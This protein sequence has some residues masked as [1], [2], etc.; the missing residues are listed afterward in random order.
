[1]SF[2][3]LNLMIS[4]VIIAVLIAFVQR[5]R[6]PSKNYETNLPDGVSSYEYLFEDQLPSFDFSSAEDSKE[7]FETLESDYK[8]KIAELEEKKKK[9]SWLIDRVGIQGEIIW[10]KKELSSLRLQYKDY[11]Q[12]L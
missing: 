1:M 2:I 7:Y 3:V 9:E 12:H 6:K 8:S 5:D 11:C 10:L 4:Y